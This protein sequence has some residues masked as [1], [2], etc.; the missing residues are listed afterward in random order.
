MENRL[1]CVVSNK[2]E[3]EIEHQLDADV[4]FLLGSLPKY[5]VHFLD[6]DGE[7]K[8]E[9]IEKKIRD[10]GYEWNEV[11]LLAAEDRTLE[12]GKR[13]GLPVVAFA[14]SEKR[15]QSYKA[16]EVVVE[17]FEEID[18]YFLE[19]VFQRKH[20]IPWRVIETERTYL[21]EMTVEDLDDLY[22]IYAQPGITDYVEPLYEDREEEKEYT[23]AYIQHMYSYYG[24]GMWLVCDR[25]ND[26]IIGRA[27]LNIQEIEGTIELEMGY[28][29]RKEY[30]R[31]GYALEV[32]TAIL[33]YAKKELDFQK[34]NC[35][36][37]KGN[38]ISEKLLEK[39]GFFWESEIEIRG[40][41]MER[42]IYLL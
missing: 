9:Q 6:L 25:Q 35:L 28:L 42:Y 40:I 11:L 33:N 17:G 1:K 13:I 19:K 34:I 41:I 14:N 12:S 29:I 3:L 27:G 39:L 20:G 36:V 18:F 26:L 16:A 30:Q 31:K 5:D 21:R 32:C 2:R 8:S 37:K 23:K 10:A 4:L 24:Y 7:I 15:E 38:Q 22:E